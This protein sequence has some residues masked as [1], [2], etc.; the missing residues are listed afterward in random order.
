MLRQ[1]EILVFPDALVLDATGLAQVFASANRLSRA[2]ADWLYDVTL[3]AEETQ[4]TCN[5]GI[6]LLFQTLPTGRSA[7]DTAIV[8]GCSGVNIACS[9]QAL[10]E[11]VH[12]RAPRVRRMA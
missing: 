1:I 12:D 5:S 2:T 10:I 4:V 3:V 7:P 6:T 8:A 9:S 11:L